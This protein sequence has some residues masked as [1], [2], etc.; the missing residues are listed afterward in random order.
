MRLVSVVTKEQIRSVP[1]SFLM[2]WGRRKVRISSRVKVSED[3]RERG[4]MTERAGKEGRRGRTRGA[5][6]D[7]AALGTAEVVAT[8]V[9]KR[10]SKLERTC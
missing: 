5:I 6:P 3:E 10:S 4:T 1:V 8:E 9:S 7:G 2:S